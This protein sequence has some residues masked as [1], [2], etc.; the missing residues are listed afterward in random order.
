[1]QSSRVVDE[2]HDLFTPFFFDLGGEFRIDVFVTAQDFIFLSQNAKF[3]L[4]RD[5]R[6]N[7]LGRQ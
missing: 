2:S 5:S 4:G 1:M 6:I 3:L 7:D